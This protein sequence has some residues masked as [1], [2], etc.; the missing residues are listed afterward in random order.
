MMRNELN[1]L[2]AFAMVSR[3]R[4]FT[5][6]AAKLGVSQSALS[7]TIRGLE[8][9][10]E[11]RLLARTTKSVAPTAAGAA[12][13][14]DLSP[15]LEQIAAALDGVRTLRRRPAGRLR[16]VMSR[17]AAVMV[18]LPRLTAFA[19]AYPDIVL[20]VV[21]VTG[22][23]D[24]VAGE[25]DAGIQLG[26]YIQKDMIAV[27]VTPELR[28][29]VVGS[30]GYFS[31]RSVPKKPRDLNDHRC[32][33]LRLPGGPSRWEF[34]RAQKSATI[35]VSGPLIIDD[36]HLVIQAALAGVGL[37]LVYEEQVAEYIAE[38]R[39]IRVLEDWTPPIPGFFLYY[40]SRQLQPAALSA[41]VNALRHSQQ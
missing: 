19:E 36:T 15:A 12:L 22:P 20:D 34:E 17:S 9:R 24:L 1:E 21:T 6:A 16:I 32:I 10:L 2:A 23:V 31:S 14:K 7:H 38:R 26:E 27:R 33:A 40:P 4:S 18:L 30:P 25:F 5:R 29:A 39:L 37:G 41:L 13:L 28:L 11:L 3:E 8:Q 35:S